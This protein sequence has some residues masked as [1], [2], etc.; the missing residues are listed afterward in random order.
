MS[1]MD[2]SDPGALEQLFQRIDDKR[3][4]L[5]ALARDLVRLPT[6]N[7]P[8]EAYTDCAELIGERLRARG[9]AVQYVRAEGA[10]GDSNR[11]PRT[12]VIARREGRTGGRCV[13]FN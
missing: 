13:H 6:V 5:V 8:G 1:G 3:D 2:G 9:F 11:Y 10:V 7:P 12:N 4:E